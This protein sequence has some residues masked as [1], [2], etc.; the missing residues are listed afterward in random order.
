[1]LTGSRQV[2]AA[3][4]R[5]PARKAITSR[6]F[7]LF[8]CLMATAYGQEFRASI[9]G[10]VTDPT[11][12]AVV[13]AK[14]EAIDVQRKVTSS[15]TTNEAGQ[16]TIGFLLPSTY[17]LTVTSEG[18]KKY[19]HKNFALGINDRVAI[20]VKMELG[21]VSESVTVS[22]QVSPLQTETANRGGIVPTEVVQNLPNNGNNAFNLV[23]LMPGA[24]RPNY[25]QNTNFGLA[26]T[27][28]AR[29][30]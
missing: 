16:Y 23:F 21:A 11:G 5:R 20:D 19:E 1:M 2:A 6:L 14:V 18:F 22:G 13:G 8:W 3:Q 17:V 24:Q 4:R 12:A 29:C 10:L 7:I 30:S 27:Q 25:S 26:G 9:S 28:G 15:A